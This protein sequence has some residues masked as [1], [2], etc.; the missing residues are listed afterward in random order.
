MRILLSRAK[1]SRHTHQSLDRFC[2]RL[3]SHPACPAAEA[4]PE[5]PEE[6]PRPL[7]CR[8]WFHTPSAIVV[9]DI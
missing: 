2:P 7:R 3:Y 4:A 5:D 1:S 6:A 8:E 9:I